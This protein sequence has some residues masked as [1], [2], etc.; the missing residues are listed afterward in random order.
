MFK[1]LKQVKDSKHQEKFNKDQQ[2]ARLTR[3]INAILKV[4]ENEKVSVMEGLDIASNL[5]SHLNRDVIRISSGAYKLKQEYDKISK[6]NNTEQKD[7]G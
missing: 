6:Q 5:I 7:K 1:K 3:I 4:F 2:I